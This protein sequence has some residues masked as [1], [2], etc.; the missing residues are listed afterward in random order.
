MSF[1][2]YLVQGHIQPPERILISLGKCHR[3]D[4]ICV[5]M[6]VRLCI[7]NSYDISYSLEIKVTH[8]QHMV[9]F[10]EQDPPQMIQLVC[11]S[12]CYG[13]MQVAYKNPTLCLIAY[14]LL[15]TCTS[16]QCPIFPSS[17]G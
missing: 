4:L 7:D 2:Q 1:R 6:E 3:Q 17:T 14:T 15:S 8:V 10:P 9:V 13:A 5:H 12:L 16:V 11:L